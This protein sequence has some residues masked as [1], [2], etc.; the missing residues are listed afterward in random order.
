MVGLGDPSHNSPLEE[1]LSY[2][3]P[4]GN[5]V[6]PY[7]KEAEGETSSVQHQTVN[8]AGRHAHPF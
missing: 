1:E 3:V 4:S 7:E 5:I 2:L 8:G 6:D